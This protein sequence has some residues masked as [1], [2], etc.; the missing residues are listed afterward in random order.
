M[1]PLVCGATKNVGPLQI[2]I[3]RADFGRRRTQ[4]VERP[5]VFP[6]ERIFTV[7]AFAIGFD[8]VR[9][10]KFAAI[11]IAIKHDSDSN[12]P[13]ITQ[14]LRNLGVLFG[15][16]KHRKEKTCQYGDDRDNDQK[17]DKGESSVVD[18]HWIILCFALARRVNLLETSA[19]VAR[20]AVA[21]IWATDQPE[22]QP[23]Q[24]G[25]W[26]YRLASSAYD[27]SITPF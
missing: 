9:R 26:S 22:Q 17:L 27:A 2:G 3:Q 11:V 19:Q 15:P 6:S 13:K 5:G 1:L 21:R 24:V 7:L 23:R 20:I 16:R 8:N 4:I 10:R 12:L 14:A 25:T 18:F